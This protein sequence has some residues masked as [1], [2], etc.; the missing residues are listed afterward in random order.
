MGFIKAYNSCRSGVLFWW[1]K[2][3]LARINRQRARV[4]AR[5]GDDFQQLAALL[6]EEDPI[7]IDLG[8]NTDEYEPEAR[9]ILPRLSG[10][11]SVADVQSVVHEEFCTWFDPETAGPRERYAQIAARIVAE[12]P[13][14]FSEQHW[15]RQSHK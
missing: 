7:H 8:D 1:Y 5:L 12:F 6:F 4:Q 3:K 2:I 14:L 9:T 11:R 15:P 13:H 10:C